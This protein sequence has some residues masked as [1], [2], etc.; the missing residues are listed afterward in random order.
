MCDI[1]TRYKEKLQFCCYYCC[2]NGNIYHCKQQMLHYNYP[3]G[4]DPDNYGKSSLVFK[5]HDIKSLSF[6]Y[7]GFLIIEI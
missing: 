4:N 7:F 2:C 3:N 5:H 6:Y 1:K